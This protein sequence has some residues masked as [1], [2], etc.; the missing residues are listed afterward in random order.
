MATSTKSRLTGERPAAGGDAGF[1]AGAARGGLSR[2]AGPHRRRGASS[3]WAAGRVSSRRRFLR[4]GRDVVGVDY[5]S[6]AVATAAA[7]L[8]PRRPPGGPDG[9]RPPGHLWTAASTRR[10]RPHLI[11][12]FTEPEAHVAELARVVRDDGLVCVLTPNKPAD[13]ENPF[14]LHLFDRDRAARD[15]RA[16]LRRGLARRGRR[17][18]PREGGLRGPPRPGGQA[19][20]ARRVRPAPPHALRRGTCGRTRR[21]LPLAYKLVARSDTGGVTGITA[22]DWFVTDDPDDTTL[23]LFAVARRPLPG[24][25]PARCWRSA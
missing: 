5:S 6:D 21:L 17:R 13:F 3:T 15:A 11:E 20:P 1:A 22:D 12:H 18:R 4:P 7:P 8:R 19:A 25:P 16:P 2:R 24:R 9:R 23:V 14:H 10:A